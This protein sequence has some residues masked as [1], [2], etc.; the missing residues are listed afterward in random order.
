VMCVQR[1]KR[2]NSE[3]DRREMMI[4]NLSGGPGVVSGFLFRFLFDMMIDSEK[5]KPSFVVS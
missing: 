5:K 4:F 3:S 1:S 2:G